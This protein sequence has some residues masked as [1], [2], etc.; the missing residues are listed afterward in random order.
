M[1]IRHKYRRQGVVSFPQL[2]SNPFHSGNLFRKAM[3]F[4]EDSCSSIQ[5][6]SNSV[7]QQIND[8]GKQFAVSLCVKVYY[9]HGIN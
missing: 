6:D 7:R 5:L 3:V 4:P 9:A 1:C 2:G 8:S